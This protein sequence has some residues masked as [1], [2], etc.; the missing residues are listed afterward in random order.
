MIAATSSSSNSFNASKST[1]PLSFDL[2]WTMSNP[3]MWALAGF[4]PCAESGMITFFLCSPLTSKYF[5][6]TIIPENSPWA[7]AAGCKLTA[8]IPV[9]V[10]NASCKLYI[11]FKAPW[12]SSSFNAGWRFK[13]PS[14]FASISLTLGLY[15]IVQEPKG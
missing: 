13:K 2:T 14:K 4:V 1:C 12:T 8:C 3:A 6:I 7:P 5:L 9:I 15:F 11:N 10:F